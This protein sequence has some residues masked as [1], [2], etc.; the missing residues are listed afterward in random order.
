MVTRQYSSLRTGHWSQKR[1]VSREKWS[2]ECVHRE[3]SGHRTVL[4][5]QC[6]TLVTGEYSDYR[7]VVTGQY[8]EDRA[9]VIN[10]TVVTG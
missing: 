4:W 6:R 9:L 2:K 7:I 8:S 10:K 3:S 1:T 5:S